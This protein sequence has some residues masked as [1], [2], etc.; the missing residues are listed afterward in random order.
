MN[1]PKKSIA[2]S[3]RLSSIGLLVIVMAALIPFIARLPMNKVYFLERHALL[4]YFVAYLGI[5]LFLICQRRFHLQYTKDFLFFALGFLS[6]VILQVFQNVAYPGFHDVSFLPTSDNAGLGFDLAARIV[7]AMFFFVGIFYENKTTRR[8][9][10]RSVI[11]TYLGSLFLV[12][13]IVIYLFM[14][15]PPVFFVNGETTILKSRLDLFAAFLLFVAALF[16]MRRYLKDGYAIYY[17]F[18]IATVFGVFTN[19]YLSLWQ[20][21]FDVFFDVGHALKIFVFTSFLV[22]IFAEHIRFLKIETELRESLEKTKEEIEKRE[23]TYRELVEKMAD[24][25]TVIDKG[26]SIVFSNQAFAEMLKY[27]RDE[28]IGIH[29]SNF[30]DSQ[31]YD[32]IAGELEQRTPKQSGQHEIEILTRDEEKLPVLINMTP[33]TDA[34]GQYAGIQCV[35]TDL[36]ERKKIEKELEDLVNKKTKDIEIFQQCIENSTDGIIITDLEGRIS[37]LNHAFETMTGFSK[38]ELIGETT[39]LLK[40]N[41][42]ATR[43]MKLFGIRSRTDG[44]GVVS[45]TQKEKMG[46]G[47]S[48]KS[49]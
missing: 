12:A 46:V 21:Y 43:F 31:N 48:V 7:F 1:F 16:L 24:G 40:Y 34:S 20:T 32:K 18:L 19:I 3:V 33:I 30:F 41:R 27:K 25:I 4:E 8:P 35:V 42:R 11:L 47:S 23:R 9:S 22:G 6:F 44:Y 15:L 2:L 37:Y 45:F 36:S 28:V 10:S 49:P 39:S 26:G 13:V 29:F 38:I 17:W 5:C 14:F